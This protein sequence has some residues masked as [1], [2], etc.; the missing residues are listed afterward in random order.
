MTEPPSN[1]RRRLLRI[2]LR[3][4]LVL[5]TVGCVWLGWKV[6]RAQKQRAA[7]AWVEEMGGWVY[8]DGFVDENGDGLYEL[9]EVNS[10]GP[11]WLREF[12]G[13][14]LLSDVVAGNCSGIATLTDIAVL[15]DLQELETVNLHRTPVDDI[16]PLSRLNN[17]SD[18]NIA[19]THVRNLSPLNRL[20][21]L[22]TL[23]VSGTQ[24]VDAGKI[25]HLKSLEVL[26]V[27]DTTFS[28]EELSMFHRALP[29]CDIRSFNFIDGLLFEE[30]IPVFESEQ[31]PEQ[32]TSNPRNSGAHEHK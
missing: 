10:P 21:K 24:A 4:F 7:V 6:N 9:S 31:L 1:S 14:D 2:S 27:I 16:S 13:I 29:N 12:V 26:R 30:A 19:E 8:Y 17:L 22:K 23:D 5:L 3:T 20:R 15:G 25:A 18:L 32:D 28:E 11:T